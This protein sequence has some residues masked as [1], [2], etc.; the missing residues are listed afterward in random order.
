MEMLKSDYSSLSDIA[1]TLGYPNIYDF[2]RAFKK[3]TGIAPS[4]YAQR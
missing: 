4:K 1:Q 2:S 3:H